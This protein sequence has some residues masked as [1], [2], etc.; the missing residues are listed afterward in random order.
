MYRRDLIRTGAL[1]GLGVALGGIG[2]TAHAQQ[3]T[4]RLL[5]PETDPSQIR[6]WQALGAAWTGERRGVTYQPEYAS[7][8]DL[9]RKISADLM[10]G[11]PPEIVA[12][13]SRVGFMASA[14]RRNLLMDLSS[15][16]D[17][18]GREDF[19]QPSLAAWNFNGVQAAIPYGAQWPVL[20]CRTDLFEEAGVPL[21]RTWDD[22][23]AAA[24]KMTKPAQG[25][26]GACF[27]AGRTWNTQIQASICIWSAGG[28]IFD[29]KLN[30]TLDTPE[31]RRAMT[32]YAEM[33]RFSPPDIGQYGFREASAAYTSGKAAT[34]FYWGRVL[35][36]LYQQA[37]DLLPK[38]R[39]VHIPYDKRPATAYG[40][41]EF[42][43]Y[44]GRNAR[45]AMDFV[46]YMLQPQQMF[47][48]MEP[49]IAHVVPTRNSVMPM[50]HQH[51]W[52]RKHPEIVTTLIE[53]I[54]FG[55][56]AAYEGPNHPFNYKWDAFEARN[57]IPDM[58]QR[59]VLGREPVA[60]SV[61]KAHRE[62]VAVT[63]DIRP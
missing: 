62:A 1:A 21:P 27:P 47:M 26:F 35:S 41:D 48:L 57:I 36:H 19:H 18:L 56:S 46:K 55:I 30:V 59:I 20:W 34:T 54:D 52:I 11:T 45:L 61:E 23:R 16:V 4:V 24:E 42:V 14:A 63:R 53:P 38:T 12:G 43:V 8:D 25:I 44:R 32:Y 15:I 22:Y 2:R 33:C 60:I 10:A 3:G 58:V 7:W 9:V 6:V 29:E 5:T 37:P 13:S 51:E 50:L 40:W 31:V 39:T 17:E 28:Q 49:V